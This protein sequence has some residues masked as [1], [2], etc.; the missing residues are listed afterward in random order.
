[1]A[2]EIA[3][4]P[5]TVAGE[6]ALEPL[7]DVPA[8]GIGYS[9]DT[10]AGTL[11]QHDIIP[12]DSAT[13]VTGSGSVGVSATGTV[14]TV[15]AEIVNVTGSGS[16]GVDGTGTVSAFMPGSG[17][18]VV[19]G[20]ADLGFVF[21][22]SAYTLV[23]VDGV[24]EVGVTA[25]G[26]IEALTD[27]E[28][29]IVGVDG[30][31]EVGVTATGTIAA[32]SPGAPV[33]PVTGTGSV[34]V[35]ATGT[36]YVPGSRD[37]AVPLRIVFENA[38]I[39]VGNRTFDF[40]MKAGDTLPALRFSIVDAN[41]T[42]VDLEGATVRVLLGIRGLDLAVDAFAAIEGTTIVYD[43]NGGPIEEAGIYRLEAEITYSDGRIVSA[44]TLDYSTVFIVDDL[45]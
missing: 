18:N 38:P 4:D 2:W 16:V 23:G 37:F 22:A 44:P 31:G 14:T 15:A 30:V 24:G 35:S 42:P 36:V 33:V 25:T 1:V 9:P 43:W 11:Q 21:S 3:P 26:T 29:G 45:G 32:F 7:L 10:I 40:A 39:A 34:D 19:S 13:V 20:T 6:T 41:D 12:P 8:W 5:Q 27:E 28:P 17:I